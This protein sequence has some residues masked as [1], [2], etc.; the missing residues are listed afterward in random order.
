MLQPTKNDDHTAGDM[1]LHTAQPLNELPKTSPEAVLA[2]ANAD[3][4][5]AAQPVPVGTRDH[6]SK[7][8][9]RSQSALCCRQPLLLLKWRPPGPSL[10]PRSSLRH[11]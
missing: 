2:A 9:S 10:A 4:T 1:S 5:Y 11:R 3:H 6:G 8:L 7:P